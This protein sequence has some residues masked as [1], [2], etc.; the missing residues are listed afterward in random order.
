M[1]WPL[2]V[3]SPLERRALA[4]AKRPSCRSRNRSPGRRS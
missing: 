3:F 1:C 4:S 2:P